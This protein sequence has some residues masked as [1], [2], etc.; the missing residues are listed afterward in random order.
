MNAGLVTFRPLSDAKSTLT[1]QMEY[2]PA[3]AVEKAGDAMGLVTRRVE[4]DLN[5]FSISSKAEAQKQA[6]GEALSNDGI[7]V[8]QKN[9]LNDAL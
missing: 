9:R 8:Y 2:V 4:E 1:L 6:R 7:G 3:G 5:R